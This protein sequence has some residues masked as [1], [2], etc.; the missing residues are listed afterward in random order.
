METEAV[1]REIKIGERSVRPSF[2]RI[3]VYGLLEL[4]PKLG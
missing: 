4:V 1:L 2:G 3:S